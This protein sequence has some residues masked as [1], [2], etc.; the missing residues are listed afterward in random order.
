MLLG[1]GLNVALL[2]GLKTIKLHSRLTPWLLRSQVVFDGIACALTIL[3]LWVQKIPT[4]DEVSRAIVCYLWDSQSPFWIAIALSTCNL[5]RI[6]FDHLLATVYCV[7]YRIYQAHYIVV[8]CIATFIY[9]ALVALPVSLIVYYTNG[10]CQKGIRPEY[11]VAFNTAKIHQ[12]LWAAAYNT[13]PL[14]FLIAVQFRVVWHI[15]AYFRLRRKFT[16]PIA[17]L[18]S[19]T[20]N[21]C[22]YGSLKDQGVA[23]FPICHQIPHQWNLLFDY[24][25]DSGTF[26]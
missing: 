26:I 9:T 24:L 10:T 18:P 2:V 23:Q 7:T 17:E 13:L 20:T 19:T 1:I 4:Y 22:N 3:I 15:K 8:C 16:A 14:I 5:M 6:T 21:K 11:V 12:D 25:H